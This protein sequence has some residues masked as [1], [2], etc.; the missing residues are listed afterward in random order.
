MAR[1]YF[2]PNVAKNQNCAREFCRFLRE[3]FFDKSLFFI[4]NLVF[5]PIPALTGDHRSPAPSPRF[6]TQNADVPKTLERSADAPRVVRRR[7]FFNSRYRPPTTSL[8]RP[9]VPQTRVPFF[10][11]IRRSADFKA[12][13]V[14][15]LQLPPL[16][17]FSSGPP[18]AVSR[19]SARRPADFIQ[20]AYIF[21]ILVTIYAGAYMPRNCSYKPL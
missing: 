16:F 15:V 8:A 14:G 5:P 7:A 18:P 3:F 12:H 1:R 17:K 9:D 20:A 10:L 11:A 21:C 2:V 13:R 6:P 4:Q 19:T